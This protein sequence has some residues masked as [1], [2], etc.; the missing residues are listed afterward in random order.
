MFRREFMKSGHI[1]VFVV[2]ITIAYACNK[3]SRKRFLKPVTIGLI[4]TGEYS[5]YSKKALMWLLHVEETE[6]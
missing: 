3:V 5:C 4:P 1:E 6:G 2:S